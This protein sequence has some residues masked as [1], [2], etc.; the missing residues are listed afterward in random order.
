MAIRM[1]PV[2][3]EFNDDYREIY[4]CPKCRYIGRVK[5]EEFVDFTRLFCAEC[6]IVLNGE[7]P[8]LIKSE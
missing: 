6:D 1:I 4:K 5:V 3:K 2:Q 8:E 7:N